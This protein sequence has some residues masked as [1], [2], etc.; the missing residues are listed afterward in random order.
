MA[1]LKDSP[2]DEMLPEAWHRWKLQE[3]QKKAILYGT[4]TLVALVVGLATGMPFQGLAPLVALPGAEAVKH[5]RHWIEWRRENPTVRATTPD[6]RRIEEQRTVEVMADA[7]KSRAWVTW[8]VLAC[9]TVPSVL[10]LMT[11]LERSVAVA[12]VD[13]RP[14]LDGDWFRLLSGTYL[15]GSYYHFAGNMGALL[16]YGAILE[17]KTSRLRLPLVYLLS[18]VAGSAASVVIPPDNI[19]SIGASGGVVGVIGYLFVFS[20]RQ[21]VKF[22]AA[23]RGAT[24]TVFFSLIVAGAFGFWYID[25]PGHAGGAL[26]GILLA[27]LMVDTARNFIGE[28]DLPLLD[29]LGWLALLALIAGSAQTSLV[30]WR[31]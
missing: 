27:G 10:Q 12:S 18:C 22:P 19:P 2:W 28:P 8:T 3:F 30:L 4:L 7:V 23:F 9:V 24:A 29:L 17:S 1:K 25:N 21:A 26:M 16:M 31:A 13:P 20:R 5:I 14:I 15:H 6:A 11:G